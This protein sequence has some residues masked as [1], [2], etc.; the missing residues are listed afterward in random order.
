M[1]G[2]YELYE[3]LLPTKLYQVKKIKISQSSTM[4]CRMCN[5]AAE[6][7]AHILSGCSA[8][9]QNKYLARHNN[10]LK[11]L[12]FELLRE[13]QLVESPPAWY[14]PIKPKPEYVSEDVQALW[15]TPTYGEN[16]ELQ[17]NRIDAKIVNHKSKEVTVVVL[18][19]SCPWIEN[20]EKKDEEKSVK[21]G[22]LR[23]ELQERYPRYTVQQ[24]NIIMGWTCLEVGQGLWKKDYRSCWGKR[25][26]MCYETCRSL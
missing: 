5:K 23:W 11:V 1:A 12:Y 20:R 14:S 21:Y 3:Q 4:S 16:H 10:V 2:V 22:L 24:Y 13:L 9:T 8:F 17:A 15:D 18:E 7:V 6:S 26:K 25:Q 19:M